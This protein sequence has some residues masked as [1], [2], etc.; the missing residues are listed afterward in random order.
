MAQLKRIMFVFGTRPEAIKMAPLIHEIEKHKDI[1]EAIVVVTGQHR[2][3]LDQALAPFNIK[4]DYDMGIMEEG[5][6]I[7]R[8]IVKSMQAF[9]DIILSDKPDMIIV[10]GDTTTTFTAG[11]SAFNHKIPVGHVE[12]GL[13]THN[14]Y[15]PFPEEMNRR[16]TTAVADLHFAP[17]QTAVDSLLREGIQRNQIFLTGNT[18]IDALFS[19]AGRPFDLKKAGIKIKEGKKII[20]VTTH[21]RESFGAP[22]RNVCEAIAKIA[23]THGEIAAVV[24]PVHKNPNVREV[25]NELLSDVHDVTLIEPMDYIPF[26]HMMKAS[27]IILTDSGGVQEEAPSLGKPVLVLREVTERPEAILANTVK[28]VGTDPELIFKETEKLLTDDVEYEKMARAV[29]PYGD[30]HASER[31]VGA[32]LRYFGYTDKNADEFDAAKPAPKMK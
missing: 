8:I 19:I 21:R 13:R 15:N 22:M 16:L 18:V 29:N 28:I 5:Q 32:L 6:T 10:Q 20:L 7:T 17:T 3:M 4:P 27:H 24:L 1:F 25:V 2:E 14:K 23:K 26:V 9:E 11:L 30:G 31:I 12:A